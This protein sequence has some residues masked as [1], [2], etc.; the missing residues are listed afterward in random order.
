[1]IKAWTEEAWEDFEYWTTQDRRMLKRILQLLKDIDRN[2]YE[3]IGKPERLITYVADRQGHDLRY[4]ID[5][6]KIHNELGWLPE[7]MFKDGIRLTIQW[8]LD[9]KEW[10]ENIVNG[11]YQN[12]YKEMYGKKGL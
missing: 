8:Y 12:Y 11:E 3:G 5:P 2:G 1:M 10:W 9:H 7:T 4:A 6:T